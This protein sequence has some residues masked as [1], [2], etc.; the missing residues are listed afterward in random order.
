MNT[1]HDAS[2]TSAQLR[3]RRER[4]IA[5]AGVVG[6]AFQ[7]TYAFVQ[8]VTL[9]VLFRHLGSERLGMWVTA[10][11]IGSWL[12]LANLGVHNAL[13]TRLGAAALTQPDHAQRLLSS[14]W[15]IITAAGA[16]LVVLSITLSG[17]LPWAGI[18]NVADPAAV[19]EA[20]PL[21]VVTLACF[22]T[23]LPASLM[24]MAL[25]SYQRGDLAHSVMIAAHLIGLIGLL[26]G[27]AMDWPLPMLAMVMLSPPIIGGLGQWWIARRRM[28]PPLLPP[29]NLRAVDRRTAAGLLH[30]GSQFLLLDLVIVGLLHTGSVIIA[31]AQGPEAV[32]PYAAMYRLIGLVLAIDLMILLPLWPAYG[33]AA[34]RGEREWVQRA[35]RRS[36]RTIMGVW[37]VTSAGIALLGPAFIRLWMGQEAVP[38]PLL[39]G[40]MLAAAL[41]YSL[42]LWVEM[43]LNGM[44][45]L[46]SR[47]AGGLLMLPAYVLLALWLTKRIGPAGVPIAQT[48][49]M[50]LIGLPINA[51]YLRR[52]M[53]R[54]MG[55]APSQDQPTA[56][57]QAIAAA[58]SEPGPGA[59]L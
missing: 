54:S 20:T 53:Q 22:A 16:A 11:T 21:M 58:A 28:N 9:A 44:G 43:P 23:S 36:G 50:L 45:R 30:T 41:A 42:M 38:S 4:F 24:G 57:Q 19:S 35:L 31:Q 59:I 29:L 13:V 55:Q 32:T 1:P 14:A 49:A 18:L 37:L 40:S 52:L 34:A 15:A 8:F 10:W 3:Q 6:V 25:L 47:V 39:L 5:R 2:A 51:F 56:S 26:A 27:V 7:I 46:R 12:L 48:A 33:E 17:L